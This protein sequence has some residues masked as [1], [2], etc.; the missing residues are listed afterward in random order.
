M[1]AR[2]SEGVLAPKG[3]M[4]HLS[5]VPAQVD[6]SGAITKG[7]KEA[8]RMMIRTPLPLIGVKGIRR[9]AKRVGEWPEEYGKRKAVLYLGH[10]IRMQEEIGTGG[11][12]FRLMYAAFLR[13]AAGIMDNKGLLDISRG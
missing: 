4:Y 2:F 6:L 5:K 1:K 13:E 9:L 8:C 7:I 12:G 11:G 10:T 3:K